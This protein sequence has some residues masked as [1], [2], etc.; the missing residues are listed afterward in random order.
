M[1]VH[2]CIYKVNIQIQ[3]YDRIGVCAPLAQRDHRPILEHHLQLHQM[4]DLQQDLKLQIPHMGELDQQ[5]RFVPPSL[6]R[7]G[8]LSQHHVLQLG[9][10]C[11]QSYIRQLNHL[12]VITLLVT[13]T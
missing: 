10:I 2:I 7:L 9:D 12:L 5:V 11:Q 1:V 6:L 4:G 3:V 8:V 13:A